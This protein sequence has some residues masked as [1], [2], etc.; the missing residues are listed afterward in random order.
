MKSYLQKPGEVKRL[1]HELDASQFTLGRLAT[2]VATLLRGKH[3]PVYT[4]HVDGG[5]FVVVINA[6]A[7]KFTGRKLLQKEYIRFTGYPG[8]IRRRFLRDV[9][10]KNPERV[11]WQAVRDMLPRNRQRANILRRLKIVAGDKHT[12]KIDPVRNSPS[13]RPSGRASAGEISNGVDKKG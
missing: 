12:F 11:V 6:A 8:G 9:M 3:K 7:V 13:Q 2:R 4:P 10:L 5:D 1:W